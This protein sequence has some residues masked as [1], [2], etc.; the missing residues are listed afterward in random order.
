MLG[1]ISSSCVGGA[2]LSSISLL[3][4]VVKG[5]IF[6]NNSLGSLEAHQTKKISV[7][8]PT[9]YIQSIWNWGKTCANF[10]EFKIETGHMALSSHTL[11]R[12]RCRELKPLTHF[13][14]NFKHRPMQ[15]IFP[16]SPIS[17]QK[18]VETLN[19]SAYSM[20]N[21]YAD[22]LYVHGSVNAQLGTCSMEI[23]TAAWLRFKSSISTSIWVVFL[24]SKNS[25]KR[26]HLMSIFMFGSPL[27]W[28]YHP[29][30]LIV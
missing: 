1:A 22:L 29:D 16:L 15:V 12:L 28:I 6:L 5:C 21:V 4:V 18:W 30:H 14:Y 17:I 11:I 8:I 2:S 26:F 19:S 3:N 25:V 7:F 9:V 10:L 23:R 13:A 27:S 24:P 20:R